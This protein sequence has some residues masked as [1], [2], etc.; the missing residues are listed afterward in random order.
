MTTD[1][2]GVEAATTSA[3][4][5]F[6]LVIPEVETTLRGAFDG[7]LPTVLP[8]DTAWQRS[9][10]DGLVL[11]L[12]T[13]TVLDSLYG[14]LGLA[15]DGDDATLLVSVN[16]ARPPGGREVALDVT[17]AQRPVWAKGSRTS[18]RPSR[19]Q[20]TSSSPESP[21]GRDR[22]VTPP[23]DRMPAVASPSTPT[24]TRSPSCGSAANNGG[25]G[26][27]ARARGR[28]GGTRRLDVPRPAGRGGAP[29][30]RQLRPGRL[31]QAPK[32]RTS[33]WA[34]PRSRRSVHRMAAEG[35][36][37][38][39]VNRLGGRGPESRRATSSGSPPSATASPW[40]GARSMSPGPPRWPR[41]DGR[42]R[43]EVLN[44]GVPGHGCAAVVAL[45]KTVVPQWTPTSRWWPS[46]P[47]TFRL[48]TPTAATARAIGLRAFRPP[49]H[50]PGT[51]A[52]IVGGAL[53]GAPAVP[54]GSGTPGRF[55]ESRP[56][57]IRPRARCAHLRRT[58]VRPRCLR[59]RA[60]VRRLPPPA[61]S[62]I[63]R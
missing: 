26:C 55:R 46:S 40:Q 5:D 10:R 42:R 56:R 37:R 29:H 9:S 2:D 28:E 13:S 7:H 53:R 3:E 45:A 18:G 43:R 27:G 32:T 22:P 25:P 24:R 38:M 36:P 60:V 51:L 16:D 1:A 57:S 59:C 4:G 44:F 20:R 12:M 35:Q 21:R 58:A 15:R 48:R 14:E 41:D 30:P 33:V 6:T 49:G 31:L 47:T 63:S 54:E 17:A 39:R 8:V 52:W 61:S 23:D 62:A 11:P 34:T 50:L 19:R